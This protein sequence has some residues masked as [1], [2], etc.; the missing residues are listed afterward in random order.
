MCRLQAFEFSVFQLLNP[1]HTMGALLTG[2][3]RM[4]QESYVSAEDFGQTYA[5]IANDQAP[6]TPPA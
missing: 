4:Q 6:P 5:V 2:V 3:K 1:V